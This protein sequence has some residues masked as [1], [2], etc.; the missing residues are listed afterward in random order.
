MR[1][2][3]PDR[4]DAS[5]KPETHATHAGANNALL[6][7]EVGGQECG[8]PVDEV[9]EIVPLCALSRPAGMPPILAGFLILDN[10]PIPVLRAARMW[11]LQEAERGLYTP[12]VVI[13]GRG[14][15][16]ALLVDRVLG[17]TN[18][19]EAELADASDIAAPLPARRVQDRVMGVLDPA[20]LLL[21][22]ERDAIERLRENEERRLGELQEAAA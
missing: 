14:R 11:G 18:A 1:P 19:A 9:R 6:T 16:L 8:I 21:A 15:V 20:R 13:R 7:V 12:L 22:L 3:P 17:V 10:E 4:D 5:H 2:A